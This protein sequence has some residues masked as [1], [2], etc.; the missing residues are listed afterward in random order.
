MNL[1][2]GF[3]KSS[4]FSASAYILFIT[5]RKDSFWLYI[6]YQG[7]NNPTTK[8]QYLLSFISKS[9]NWLSWAKH[10]IQLDMTNA[11]YQI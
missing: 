3:I 11:S 5:K 10:F 8:N 1:A 7:L 2:N 9:L 6:H 4:K